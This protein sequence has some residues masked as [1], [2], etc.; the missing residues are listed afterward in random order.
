MDID[1]PEAWDLTTGST[2]VIVAVVDGGIDYAHPDIAANMWPGI[3]KNFI[4]GTSDVT[5]ESHGTHVAGTIAA[6]TNNSV[7]VAGIAGG[8]GSGNGVRLMSCQI[9]DSGDGD[10]NAAQAIVY[11]ADNGAVICQNSWGYE[12]E[13]AYNMSD[14]AAIN[15]FIANAEGPKMKGGIVIFAA[16]NDN[17]SGNW[18]PARWDFVVSVAAI[19]SAGVRAS[20][21]NYGSWVTISA[22]GSNVL[23]TTPNGR[24]G[25]NSGTS[26]ACPHVSGVAALVLSRHGNE[27]YTPAMLRERLI[28]TAVPLS[29]DSQYQAGQMG[30][31]LVNAF[32]AVSNSVPVTGVTLPPL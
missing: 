24:Y 4:P 16:G 26:M 9:F 13:G 15:Y 25:Q 29:N 23:S 30:A 6:V 17:S 22:P 8:S 14:R 20:Y 28:S 10:G 2:D 31:G 27:T 18:Y 19:T 32:K 12:D 5:A 1:L 3:G 21:S 11:A 7:G